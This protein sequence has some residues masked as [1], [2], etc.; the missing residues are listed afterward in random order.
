MEQIK[1]WIKLHKMIILVFM[2]TSINYTAK[3]QEDYLD[4]YAFFGLHSSLN[5]NLGS[6]ISYGVSDSPITLQYNN[7]SS[8]SFGLMFQTPNPVIIQDNGIE[9]NFVFQIGFNVKHVYQSVNYQIDKS[10]FVGSVSSNDP[11]IHTDISFNMYSIPIAAEGYF[12]D[13]FFMRSGIIL[14][15]YKELSTSSYTKI[16]DI[17][18]TSELFTSSEFISKISMEV[19]FGY[20]IPTTQVLWQ[21]YIYVNVGPEN[22]V[23]GY[24]EIDG[25][26]D[27]DYDKIYGSFKQGDMFIG[28]G[29][30]VFPKRFW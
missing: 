14:G 27:R 6:E 12:T 1:D 5:Y 2:L 28:L 8:G 21:P 25:I 23:N 7:F 22:I 19:G 4:Y 18:I 13:K 17:E 26:K 20:N 16:D 15:F 11:K 29:L 9:M 3:A 10:Q 30:N 24:F